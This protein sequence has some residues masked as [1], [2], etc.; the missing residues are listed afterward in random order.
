MGLVKLFHG[1]AR[2][3]IGVEISR[4][5]DPRWRR[6]VDPGSDR[7]RFEWPCEICVASGPESRQRRDFSRHSCS[8]HRYWLRALLCRWRKAARVD[9]LD[10]SL[11]GTHLADSFADPCLARPTNK[12]ANSTQTSS[13]TSQDRHHRSSS[14]VVATSHR[15]RRFPEYP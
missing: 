2:L 7:H 15:R 6:D 9:K 5:E 12:A 3:W 14:T 13:R 10:P 1:C 4:H 8:S 11:S